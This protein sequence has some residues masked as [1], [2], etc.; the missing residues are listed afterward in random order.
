MPVSF[1]FWPLGGPTEIALA[2]ENL[3]DARVRGLKPEH[4]EI[5]DIKSGV[6]VRATQGG[7]VSFSFRYRTG[8]ARRRIVIGRFPA[9]SLADAR[10]A[11]GR[12]REAVRN[13]GDPQAERRERHT[14][15][16]DALA[17]LYIERYA[18]QQKA[19]WRADEG[20][21]GHV[22]GEWGRRDAASITRQDAARLVFDIAAKTP[23]SAN[24]TRS[25]LLKMYG[26]AVDSA[27]L[28][29]NPISGTKKPHREGKG[30]SRILRDDEIRVLWRALDSTTRG[31]G[32]VAALKTILLLGQRPGEVS[33]MAVDE[34]H[35]LEN[36]TTA[37][38]TI[39]AHR[40]KARK[41]HLVPL[42]PLAA[43]IITT[44]IE[45][46]ARPEFVFTSRFS[47]G[48]NLSRSALSASLAELIDEI[49]DA[50]GGSLKKDKPTPHDLRRSAISGMSRLGVSRD[51]RMAVAA[52][53]HGDVH[54]VYDHYDRLAEKRAA[55]EVWELHLR[56]VIADYPQTDANV[57]P[58]RR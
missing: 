48:S 8:E 52:H 28:D 6:L 14:L 11:A 23:V 33:G 4:G 20:F 45:R 25:V 12:I 26:W 56:K 3:T 32:T 49:D 5:T 41:L 2:T 16:F 13:G 36:P 1:G 50:V 17:D 58:L 57:L 38:W 19:S 39:P 22:R 18:K 55:L 51:D 31:A 34:L 46:Q 42:P 29:N 35:D 44:E 47:K 43:A 37:L 24:R 15:T 53:S 9:V 10:A 30:K 27:L 7:A 54:E 21:L 40:M